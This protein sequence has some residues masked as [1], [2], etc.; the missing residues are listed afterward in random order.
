MT[1]PLSWSTL[2]EAAAWLTATTADDWTARRVL[3][4]VT[5]QAMQDVDRSHRMAAAHGVPTRKRTPPNPFTVLQA[6]P[7]ATVKFIPRPIPLAHPP[8]AVHFG[9]PL[10]W[11][12]VPLRLAD[13]RQ[14]L[15][16]GSL[17]LEYAGDR[18]NEVSAAGVPMYV[19]ELA[20]AWTATLADI[21]LKR[22]DLL[23][24]AAA[25]P[26]VDGA[27]DSTHDGDPKGPTATRTELLSAFAPFLKKTNFRKLEGWLLAARRAP[28]KPGRNCTEPLFCPYA[29][30]RGLMGSKAAHMPQARGWHILKAEF[31]DAFAAHEHER[32]R[33]ASGD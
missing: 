13:A 22:A 6:A 32:P 25:A 27:A 24:L 23:A 17:L 28:G 5:L 4:V 11:R 1:E 12:L 29:V 10:P 14:L 9:G 8:G 33:T 26:Q 30:M 31:P 7:P 18:S 2:D 20:P 15:A 3:D 19:E 21:R 16:S